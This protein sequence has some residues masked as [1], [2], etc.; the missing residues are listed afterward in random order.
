MYRFLIRCIYIYIYMFI[1]L[2]QTHLMNHVP[3]CDN[4]NG[5]WV[6]RMI[7]V[8]S[9]G[10]AYLT[11]ILHCS[12]L[13]IFVLQTTRRSILTHRWKRNEM[14]EDWK[15]DIEKYHDQVSFVW[16]SIWAILKRGVGAIEKNDMVS[17]EVAMMI[18][19]LKDTNENHGN[20]SRYIYISIF[21]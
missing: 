19:I 7:R 20:P 18:W 9:W 15:G 21:E 5:C 3:S 8:I 10:V 6:H 17:M 4:E 16:Q 11:Y 13:C 1:D 12:I 2:H 14:Y